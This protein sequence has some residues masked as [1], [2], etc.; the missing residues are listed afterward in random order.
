VKLVQ[1]DELL[2]FNTW[3]LLAELGKKAVVV[4]KHPKRHAAALVWRGWAKEVSDGEFSI[5]ATGREALA[6]GR[7]KGLF[8]S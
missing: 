4:T 2:H 3:S 6:L 5:T 8:I 7:A 1:Q